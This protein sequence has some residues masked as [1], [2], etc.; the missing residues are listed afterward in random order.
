MLEYRQVSIL[1]SSRFEILSQCKE[2][3]ALEDVSLPKVDKVQKPVYVNV[4]EGGKLTLFTTGITQAVKEHVL[5][6]FPF[7]SGILPV[8]YLGLPLMTKRISLA[9]CMPLLEKIRARIN[10]WKNRFLSYAVG[11]NC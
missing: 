3:E 5:G 4:V 10:S 1:S 11:F 7:D 2:N 9:D 6:R 8:R